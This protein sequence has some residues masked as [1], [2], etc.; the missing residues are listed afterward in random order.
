MS[1][2]IAVEPLE[3]MIE[4]MEI[5]AKLHGEEVANPSLASEDIVLNPQWGLM[6]ALAGAGLLV[7][8]SLRSEEGTLVGYATFVLHADLHRTLADGRPLLAAVDDAHYVLPAARGPRVAMR[9]F[10]EA[11]AELRARGVRKVS[12]H[13]KA[14]LPQG[15]LLEALGFV[16][17]DIIMTTY[18]DSLEEI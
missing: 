5:L 16:P 11:L 14:H 15:R 17:N 18:L 10:V 6:L 9:L 1:L 4:E 3:T 2:K 13:T 12:V 7:A 8:I